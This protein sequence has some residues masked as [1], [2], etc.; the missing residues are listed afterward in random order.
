MAELSYDEVLLETEEKMEG[1]I[2]HLRMEMRGM[3]TGRAH[4]GL[5]ENIRV[6]YYGVP[7]PLKQIANIGIPEPQLLVVKPFDPGSLKD[8]EKAI[9]KSDAGLMPQNDGN[10]I[11]LLVPALS[12]ERREKLVSRS[13]D[14]AEQSRI[15]IRN[16]RRE[17]NKR[18]DG[19]EKDKSLAKDDAAKLR[20]E[21][22]ELTKTYESKISNLMSEKTREL[23][24]D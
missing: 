12:E 24:E 22:Q 9:H 17:N 21:I 16:V 18:A 8:I 19:M 5:I 6:D 11:R 3:R 14:I 10:L 7:T 2:D 20:D 1:A 15:S 4:P 13:K 23:L